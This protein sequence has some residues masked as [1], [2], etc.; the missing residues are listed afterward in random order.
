MLPNGPHDDGANVDEWPGDAMALTTF[1]ISQG[2]RDVSLH[3]NKALYKAVKLLAECVPCPTQIYIRRGGYDY[4][5]HRNWS[6]LSFD[7]GIT[8]G[9]FVEF[10]MKTVTM[11]VGDSSDDCR[12][13]LSLAKAIELSHL[14]CLTRLT[15][16]ESVVP[17]L[18]SLWASIHI[19]LLTS[20]ALLIA[21][22]CDRHTLE[23]F[24]VYVDHTNKWVRGTSYPGFF[25]NAL[26]LAT[27]E[28]SG[29]PPGTAWTSALV[30]LRGCAKS[31][32]DTDEVREVSAPSL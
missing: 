10:S 5:L 15:L 25:I 2:I 19:T 14:A 27:L 16:C 11:R 22:R 20:L 4:G 29:T 28:L 13:G 31:I 7:C 1:A 32:K 23:L 24:D 26:K 3:V 18:T 6:G 17:K 8:D 9:V 12:H 21:A 30:N